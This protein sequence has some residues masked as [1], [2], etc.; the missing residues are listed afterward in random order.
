M[1]DT[2]KEVAKLRAV[3]RKLTKATDPFE[4]V[5]RLNEPL[6]PDL[7]RGVRDFIPGVWPTM[8]E[9]KA[10]ESAARLAHSTLTE[11]RKT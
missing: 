10:L 8:A 1:T 7:D 4:R 6:T 9:L 5:W 2:T 11:M 3:I